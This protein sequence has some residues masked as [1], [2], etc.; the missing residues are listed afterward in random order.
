MCVS[1]DGGCGCCLT[2]RNAK[3]LERAERL[4]VEVSGLLS[5][6]EGRF[7]RLYLWCGTRSELVDSSDCIFSEGS[8]KRFAREVDCFLRGFNGYIFDVKVLLDS[9]CSC[10][11]GTGG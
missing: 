2:S 3:L 11:E 6:R 7:L 9:D 5:L 8:S 1:E 4:S 10:N